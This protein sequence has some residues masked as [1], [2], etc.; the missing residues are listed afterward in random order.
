MRLTLRLETRTIAG[1]GIGF[2]QNFSG[3]GV[4]DRLGIG[5]VTYKGDWVAVRAEEEFHGRLRV[6]SIFADGAAD[7][8][9]RTSTRRSSI[10][11]AE[12]PRHAGRHA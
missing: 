9:P 12:G 7:D 10:A 11:D 5:T 8:G 1:L 2:V 6:P 3:S 4:T